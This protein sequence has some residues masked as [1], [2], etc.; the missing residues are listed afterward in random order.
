[1]THD[2]AMKKKEQRLR[3]DLDRLMVASELI[4]KVRSGPEPLRHQ[5]QDG[6]RDLARSVRLELHNLTSPDKPATDDVLFEGRSGDIDEN[7]QW[8][9]VVDD[10]RPK[11][12]G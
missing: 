11:D 8:T 9:I 5:V 10:K 6:L 1:M 12:D 3:G 7:G 2:E 4:R